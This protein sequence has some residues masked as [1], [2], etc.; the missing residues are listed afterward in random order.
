MSVDLSMQKRLAADILD[1]GTG[2][3]WM[4]PDREAGISSAITRADVRSL[5][6]DGAIKAK[7]KKSISS[8]R[9]RKR[10]EQRQK[11]RR[12]GPGSRKGAEKARLP[13]KEA[14][15]KR[16]RPLRRR[17]RE[18]RDEGSIDSGLYRQLY[19]MVKGGSFRSKAH[20]ESYLKKRGLLGE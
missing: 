16:V 14:W 12:R 15:I 1:V 13:K 2:R 6:D 7:P 18:L 9:A 17:L 8:G 10:K 3:V 4:D 19:R 11:G 5:I 20:L